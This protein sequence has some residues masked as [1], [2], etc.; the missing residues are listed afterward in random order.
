[1]T[2]AEASYADRTCRTVQDVM[3]KQLSVD[4]RPG[5][6]SIGAARSCSHCNM[7]QAKERAQTGS[8]LA[9]F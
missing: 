4:D 3:I 7:Q 5:T 6:Y 1:M 8:N 9:G 2:V